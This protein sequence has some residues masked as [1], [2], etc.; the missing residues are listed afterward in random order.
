[1]CAGTCPWSAP[2]DVL[3]V[4]C[5]ACVY[6]VALCLISFSL[7]GVYGRSWV[8]SEATRPLGQAGWRKHLGGI[9][10]K[11]PRESKN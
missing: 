2:H 11:T 1:M 10:E 8:G 5:L 7:A 6:L 9:T 4:G 3:Y